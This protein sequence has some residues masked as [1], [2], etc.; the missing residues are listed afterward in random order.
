MPR[1]GEEMLARGRV[2]DLHR[3]IGPRRGDIASIG[4]PGH[5]VYRPPVSM[6]SKGT[7]SSSRIPHMYRS[8]LARG[9]DAC[10]IRGPRYRVHRQYM[11]L[12][13]DENGSLWNRSGV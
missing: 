9:S 5:R 6:I 8:I 4:R 1:I 12:I 11:T 13:G 7:V 10:A 3:R 2:P